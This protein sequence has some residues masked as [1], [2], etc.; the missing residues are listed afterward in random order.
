MSVKQPTLD[1]HISLAKGAMWIWAV[2]VVYL[3]MVT[4][5]RTPNVLIFTAT[6]GYRHDSIPAAIAMFR[7]QGPTYGINFTFSE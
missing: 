3:T 6:A 5:Q 4:A 2:L 1:L 7:Q